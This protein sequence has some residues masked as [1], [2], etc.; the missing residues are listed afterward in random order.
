MSAIAMRMRHGKRIR[1]ALNR[2]IYKGEEETE[3][4]QIVLMVAF[5]ASVAYSPTCAATAA[6]QDADR[7]APIPLWH[8]CR[9]PEPS[10]EGAIYENDANLLVVRQVVS[11]PRGVLAGMRIDALSS[12]PTR[13]LIFVGT[14]HQ[15][16]DGDTLGN[17][18]YRSVGTLSY[19]NGIGARKTVYAFEEIPAEEQR[20]LVAVRQDRRATEEARRKAA[21]ERRRRAEQSEEFQKSKARIAAEE[22]AEKER[23]A[24]EKQEREN[25]AEIAKLNAEKES[26]MANMRDAAREEAIRQQAEDAREM[27]RLTRE[28]EAQDRENRKRIDAAKAEQR[29]AK[30]KLDIEQQKERLRYAADAL[31]AFDFNFRRHVVIQRSIRKNVRVEIIDPEWS[32]FADLQ[33]KQDWLGL[34]GAI[35]GDEYDEFP[36]EK[37]MNTIFSTLKERT[38][39]V[40]VKSM[41]PPNFV[42]VFAWR[43]GGHSGINGGGDSWGHFC[44]GCADFRYGP[45]KG[46]P[47]EKVKEKIR[48][49]ELMVAPFAKK[50]Y[51]INCSTES[52]MMRELGLK[53]GFDPGVDEK[54]DE[55]EE[56]LK[57]N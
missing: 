23:L 53:N 3:M 48:G 26:R 24:R 45:M 7:I 38:F 18:F 20:E 33:D 40:S 25:A 15:Y 17:G 21:S 57:L 11:R 46:M 32:K 39:R 1:P 14:T 8:I 56:W 16:A 50:V 43:M 35:D 29:Q 44:V 55:I 34:L 47:M 9:V 51:V 30:A 10:T 49:E 5:A 6:E 2:E 41:R 27:A 37:E 54:A 28:R 12:M 42:S 52:E 19:E 22:T 31:S 4:K 36:S 13:D